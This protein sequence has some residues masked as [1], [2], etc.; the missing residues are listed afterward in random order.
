MFPRIIIKQKHL[1]LILKPRFFA[2]R[3][4]FRSAEYLFQLMKNINRR[5]KL[6][7]TLA[8]DIDLA[9]TS[10]LELIEIVKLANVKIIYDIGAHTGTWSFLAKA[11][12][13]ESIIHA[14]EPIKLHITEFQNRMSHIKDINL[15][16]VALGNQNGDM[17]IKITNRSDSSSLLDSTE[18]ADEQYGVKKDREQMIKIFTLDDYIITQKIPLPDFIK[19]DVQGYELE[20]LKGSQQCIKYAKWILCEVSFYSYYQNQPLFYDICEHL[21]KYQ[22]NIYA[23]GSDTPTGSI[24]T[25]VDVLFKRN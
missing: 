13:P 16:Q 23:F 11:L 9:Y 15:H 21:K 12:I 18:L 19:L 20:V 10:S 14:F 4:I 3:L 24:L 17:S 22:Y 5:Q 1:R 2:V 25:Q 6:K 7:G 8:E